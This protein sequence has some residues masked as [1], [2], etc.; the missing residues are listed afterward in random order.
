MKF[1]VHTPD[2][3]PAGA[4]EI[5]GT[6][7]RSYGFVPNLAAVLAESP[8]TLNGLL[9]FMSAYDAK[10]MTLSPVER[11]VVLL[12][13]SAKNG[14][15]YC[16]AAHGMLA[17]KNGLDRAEVVNLQQG[18]PLRDAKLETLRRFAEMIAGTRG[19]ASEAD[20]EAF[21][22]AGF[23]RAQVFEVIFGV[24]L[25]TLTNYANHI[26][27]PPVNEQFAAFLPSWGDAA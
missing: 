10:E 24:A 21:F 11:Q 13:V 8:A 5:L 19:R 14:C 4:R 6:I 1:H 12:A 9:G 16:A 20:L 25:K 18:R 2:S 15:E 3:A 26:A 7:A 22:T 23:S 27:R 17:S